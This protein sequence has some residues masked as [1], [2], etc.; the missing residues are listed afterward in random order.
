MLLRISWYIFEKAYW[1]WRQIYC[2]I[3]P[4]GPQYSKN[5]GFISWQNSTW[6]T[7]SC[8]MEKSV[9]GLKEVYKNRTW[10]SCDHSLWFW[11][12]AIILSEMLNVI[13]IWEH[14]SLLELMVNRDHS[15]L[16]FDFLVDGVVFSKI[17]YLVTGLH[18]Q[19]MHFLLSDYDPHSKLAS[20]F[21]FNQKSF[22][23]TLKEDFEF[24]NWNFFYLFVPLNF[25]LLWCRIWWQNH[26]LTGMI[27]NLLQCT[28]LVATELES[29][30]TDIL[31]G[32]E[33]VHIDFKA[34]VNPD[35]IDCQK[36]Y[37]MAK[38][39]SA[40]LYGQEW[41][42][43]KECNEKVLTL[44]KVHSWCNYSSREL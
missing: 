23:R 10:S 29:G 26:G 40:S 28:T 7:L 6:E 17:F 9:P 5:D 16:D 35:I 18:L 30:N 38:K 15:E 42:K 2:C 25:T 43:I 39:W 20:S 14:L 13:K 19:L 8:C 37:E 1:D 33:N 31:D 27:W 3:T 21:V 34:E 36:K 11:H 24:S 4:V 41:W 22:W 12:A 44:T 32:D